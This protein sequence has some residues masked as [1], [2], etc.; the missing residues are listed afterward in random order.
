MNDF[1][2]NTISLGT[3]KNLMQEFHE[4]GP[5][6]MINLGGEIEENRKIISRKI[7]C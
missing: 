1:D 7:I 4:N 3:Q 5:T 6:N 2:K